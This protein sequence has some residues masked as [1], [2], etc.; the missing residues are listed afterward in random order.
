MSD[1]NVNMKTILE[2]E[3]EFNDVKEHLIIK[4]IDSIPTKRAELEAQIQKLKSQI[5]DI[6]K[7][8]VLTGQND[9]VLDEQ[10]KNNIDSKLSR[11]F[12]E[13]QSKAIKYLKKQLFS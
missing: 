3:N 9:R 12:Q 4:Y 8:Q 5:N 6:E 10:I 13:N 1:D 2:K 11:T 7:E